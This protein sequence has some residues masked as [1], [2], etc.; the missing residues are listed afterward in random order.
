VRPSD[1]HLSDV[2][3]QTRAEIELREER[4][5]E[6]VAPPW[7]RNELDPVNRERAFEDLERDVAG[8][9]AAY[10]ERAA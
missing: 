4:E 10:E 5:R 6:A 1:R 7:I 2:L 9:L 3:H 8:S